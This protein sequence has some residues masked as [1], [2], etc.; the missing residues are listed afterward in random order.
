MYQLRG[1]VGRSSRQSYAYLLVPSP[2]R[3]SADAGQRLW[4]LMDCEL[5]GGFKL[6]MNDLQIRGG[7]NLLGVSQ[8]G[9]I[10]AVGYDLYLELLQ[11]TVADLKKQAEQGGDLAEPVVEPDVKLRVAAFLPDDYVRDTVL[12]YRL[13][14]RLSV[15]GNEDPEQLADLRD[16]IRDRFG[17]IPRETEALFD[18]VGLKYQLRQLGITKLE[19]GPNN[20][21]FSFGEHSPV[22]PETLLAFIEYSRP[23][24]KKENRVVRSVGGLRVPAKKP[25]PDPVR[26]TPDQRLIVM[27]GEDVEQGE[28]FQRI[29]AV[30]GFLG[31]H[32]RKL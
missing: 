4:A 31:T 3:M 13:Y 15:A 9:H 1:R 14:R 2:E 32:E 17:P 24:K 16:E 23:K 26:L 12:R 19:Q 28:T 20:L 22:S 8:S 18:L 27:L 7:G 30:L 10:A 21:V 5:G 6:A 25:A 29:E 11:S